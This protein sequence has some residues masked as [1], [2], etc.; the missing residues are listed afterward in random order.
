MIEK[1][2][3]L[4]KRSILNEIYLDDEHRIQYLRACIDNR[5]K[6]RPFWRA[7]YDL[8]VLH[9]IRSALR[10]EHE[11]LRTLR[12][13]GRFV[14][15]SIHNSGFAHSMIGRARMENLHHTLDRMRQQSISGDVIECGVWRGG[16]CIFM[17]GYL[18]AYGMTDRRLFVADSFEGLPV[19]TLPQDEHLDLSKEKY[20]ELAISLETVKENF[21][22]YDLLL[23]NVHFLKG[24]FKDTLPAAPIEQIAV[25]RMDGDLYESTQDILNNL[26]DKVSPGGAIIVDDYGAIEACAHAVHDF[27]DRRSLPQPK[28]EKI[29]WGGS[30]F[31]K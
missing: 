13:E 31:V 8:A 21:R 19:P 1:Y 26:Y 7:S 20:P 30:W 15:E 10:A 23:P 2:L 16:S 24:W 28:L 14:D 11:R 3:E 25:L 27:F 29:D 4:L 9:D 18:D 5:P 17:E 22:L 12:D 6:W